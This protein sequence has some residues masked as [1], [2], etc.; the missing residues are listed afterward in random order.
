MNFYIC[1]TCHALNGSWRLHCQCCG[2]TPKQ[3]SITGKPEL[4]IMPAIGCERAKSIRH[5]KGI[6]RT[7]ELDYYAGA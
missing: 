3:Y 6:L 4:N 5:T 1:P 7:V 2:T